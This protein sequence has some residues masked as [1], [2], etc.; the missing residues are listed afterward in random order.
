MVDDD[1][2]LT[3]IINNTEDDQID[4]TDT[5]I[6]SQDGE[7]IRLRFTTPAIEADYEQMVKESEAHQE[8][9]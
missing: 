1:G 3:V 4:E 9:A 7:G 2:H 8:T 5:E 6:S